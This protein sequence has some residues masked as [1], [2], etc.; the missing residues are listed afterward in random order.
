VDGPD[1]V[2]IELY[3]TRQPSS[4]SLT[5]YFQ[6][7][8]S[9]LSQKFPDT[10]VCGQAKQT[11]LPGNGPTGVMAPICLTLTSQNGPATPVVIYEFAGLVQGSGF[12]QLFVAGIVA[13]QS[14]NSNTLVSV[15]NPV[16]RSVHW[17]Q[18][19]GG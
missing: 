12:L 4:Y 8:I 17:L 18:L 13:P 19:S 15:V 11:T 14:L 2:S 7:R 3:S 5:T 16:W 1:G 9:Q 10:K 6:N